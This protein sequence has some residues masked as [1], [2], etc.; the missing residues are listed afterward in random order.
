MTTGP[1]F[2]VEPL[3][4]PPQQDELEMPAELAPR[5]LLK[6]TLGIAAV[7]AFV[8]LVLLLAPGLG[9]LRGRLRDASPG[10]LLLAVVF[11]ALSCLSYVLM[12]RP[13]FCSH[14]SPRTSAEIAWA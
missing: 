12:F 9:E 5:R 14:M 11:E 13:I 10:W 7:L 2:R 8:G 6:R 3:G 4:K 1:S